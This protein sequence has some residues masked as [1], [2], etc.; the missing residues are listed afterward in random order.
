MI[1]SAIMNG[2]RLGLVEHGSL[3][4]VHASV[5]FKR[6]RAPHLVRFYGARVTTRNEQQALII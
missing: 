2:L 4:F 1:L 6:K 5:V 3:D